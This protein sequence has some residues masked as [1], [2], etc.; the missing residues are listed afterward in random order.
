M[1]RDLLKERLLK[2]RSQVSSNRYCLGAAAIMI[3]FCFVVAAT[4]LL[5]DAQR[6]TATPSKTRTNQQQLP[7][8]ARTQART[9]KAAR[10]QARTPKAARKQPRTPKAARKQ[11]RTHKAARKQPRTHKAAPEQPSEPPSAPKQPTAPPP[12]PLKQPTAP[13]RSTAPKARK[14]GHA[15]GPAEP[16][17]SNGSGSLLRLMGSNHKTGTFAILAASKVICALKAASC[18]GGACGPTDPMR[19]HRVPCPIVCTHWNAD[20]ASSTCAIAKA[21][22]KRVTAA[23]IA[24][25]HMARDPYEVVVSGFLYHHRPVEQWLTRPISESRDPNGMEVVCAAS[26]QKN[27]TKAKKAKNQA[28]TAKNSACTNA[29]QQWRGVFTR[30]WGRGPNTDI[31]AQAKAVFDTLPVLAP[32]KRA[33]ETYP[34]Y[35]NRVPERDGLLAEAARALVRDLASMAS[36]ARASGPATAASGPATSDANASSTAST[37]T[38]CLETLMVHDADALAAEW[39]RLLPVL[40]YTGKAVAQLASQLSRHQAGALNKTSHHETSHDPAER[41]R[42]LAVVRELDREELGG[43]LAQIARLTGC[44]ANRRRTR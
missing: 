39:A 9:P 10:K 22:Y 35:L 38:S 2:K 3:M 6:E 41:A 14:N 43:A 32:S 33:T 5:E 20:L 21:K 27:A 23:D 34:Q 1:V 18:S 26:K 31:G 16:A 19:G 17:V 24:V 15:V 7:N 37:V 25:V 8:A 4:S 36:A 42:L 44:S 29:N 28:A 13:K 30:V 40:G 11:P 12:A